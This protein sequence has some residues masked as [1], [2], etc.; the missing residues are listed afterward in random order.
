MTI[1][2]YQWKGNRQVTTFLL[3]GRLWKIWKFENEFNNDLHLIFIDF[4]LAYDCINRD[5]LWTIL[6]NFEIPSK[7]V[8]SVKSCNENTLYQERY[9]GEMSES[10]EVKSGLRQGNA[11][12]PVLFNLVQ[13]QVIRDMKHSRNGTSWEHDFTSICR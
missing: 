6:T 5:Q 3:Y 11:L 12:S 1:S 13:E 2:V 8:R 4:K 9:T 7:L 10:F